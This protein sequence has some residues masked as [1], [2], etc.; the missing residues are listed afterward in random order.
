MDVGTRRENAP[1]FPLQLQTRDA[2]DHKKYA[3]CAFGLIASVV[4]N[5]TPLCKSAIVKVQELHLSRDADVSA[6]YAKWLTA[7]PL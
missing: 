3:C 6:I 7:A 5:A 4:L 2:A 1:I